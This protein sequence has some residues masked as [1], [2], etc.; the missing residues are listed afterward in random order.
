MTEEEPVIVFVYCEGPK[1]AP[2]KR[3]P[4]AT[5]KRLHL[6]LSDPPGIWSQLGRGPKIHEQFDADLLETSRPHFAASRLR[7]PCPQCKFNEI[8]NDDRRE[9]VAAMFTAFDQLVEQGKG[10]ISVR[11]LVDWIGR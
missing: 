2:H 6:N 1:D 5:Y 7:F 9:P 11:E 4:V 3:H 10:K 8:R